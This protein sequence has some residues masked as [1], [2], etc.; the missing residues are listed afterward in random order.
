MTIAGYSIAGTVNHQDATNTYTEVAET[1]V[2][3]MVDC[4]L[5][6]ADVNPSHLSLAFEYAYKPLPRFWR[7][8][9]IA[10]VIKAVSARFPDWRSA[11]RTHNQTAEVVLREVEDILRC[12]AFDEAN[13]EILMA[14]PLQ[15]RPTEAQTATD[16]ICAELRKKGLESELR[17]AE[18][19]GR[20][21]GEGALEVVHSLEQAA[22]GIAWERLGTQ[23]ARMVRDHMLATARA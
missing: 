13:A 22:S 15:A 11:V 17:F 7:D 8:F 12:H 16:W 10:T 1:V 6:D 20:R 18:R 3:F 9:D 4:G 19:D 23:T 21:C 5:K 2:S 14:L